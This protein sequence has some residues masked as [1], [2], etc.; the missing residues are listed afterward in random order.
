MQI[1]A[2]D[3]PLECCYR[4]EKERAQY[5]YMTQPMGDGIVKDFTWKQ[6]LEEARRMANHLKSLDF[7][8][9][10]K[11]A[12]L[13]KNCAHFILSDL[14]IWMAGHVS[15]ALYP[16]SA[17][18]T[19]QYILDHSETRLLF[20]GKLDAF[21][22]ST[23]VPEGMPCIAYPLAPKTNYE[24]WDDIIARTQPIEGN[25]VRDMDDSSVL[26]YTSGST[27]KPKGV[28]HTFKSMVAGP[29]GAI[30]IFKLNSEDRFI[31]YL[32]LAHV[33]ERAAIQVASFILGNRVFFAESLDTFVADVKRARPTFFHSVPRLWLKF[34]QGV[35]AKMPEKKLRLLLK[36][37]IVS[38]L[39]K[40]KILT[41]LGLDCARYAVSGS[42]PIPPQLI[43]WYRNLGLELLEGYAMTEDFVCSHISLPGKSRVGYVGNPVSGATVRLSSEGEIQIKT[44]GNMKGYYKEPELTK[45]AYTE[46]GFFKTGD[47]GEIDSQGRLRITGRVKELFKSSK[48][49]Y[50]SPAPIENLLNAD[51]MVEMS[52][53][54]GAGF[55]QPFAFVMLAEGVRKD[56]ARG[57]ADKASIT[58]HLT[59]LLAKVNSQVEEWERMSCLV[60]A[61][62]EWAID[63][64]F[65]TPTMKL[66][67]GA[68]DDTYGQEMTKWAE[69]KEKV[70][71]QQAAMSVV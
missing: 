56:L 58:A 43:D 53:V 51:E 44:L 69:C 70:V 16:T 15:V 63:N 68:I 35:S 23:T 5:I 4:W 2:R 54:T 55:P 24:K 6:T 47:R 13:S 50:I 11:I 3:L 41:G 39:I 42:A 66:K 28:E 64:G 17:P 26:I 38:G 60:I 40:K 27:G 67:R 29:K 18:D 9:G 36:I 61:R 49:K 1:E 45:E 22:A 21:D 33:F 20:V 7:P 71:W 8:P 65:L 31:S 59:A 57:T 37:P 12:I 34:Q 46:D 52:C 14:A 30:E 25:P 48:G 19:I 10:S 32:P 62:D